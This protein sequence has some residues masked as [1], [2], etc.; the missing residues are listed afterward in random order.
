MF[1]IENHQIGVLKNFLI[2][3]CSAAGG[4]EAGGDSLAPAE[5]K[6]FQKEAALEQRFASG[7]GYASFRAVVGFKPFQLLHQNLRRTERATVWVPGIRIVAVPAAETAA[8]QKNHGTDAGAV[9]QPHAFNGMDTSGY[10]MN[11]LLLMKN[12]R[13]KPAVRAFF[14]PD[15]RPVIDHTPRGLPL[16]PSV[17]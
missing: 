8:L 1:H 14:C 9:H 16:V 11:N 3:S 5:L 12:D 15:G 17:I 2:V 10:Q 13:K 7:K 6:Q 4:V